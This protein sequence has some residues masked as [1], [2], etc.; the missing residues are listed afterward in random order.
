MAKETL[1]DKAYQIIKEKIITCQYKPG[2]LLNEIEL[3]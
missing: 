1:K 3:V 2:T